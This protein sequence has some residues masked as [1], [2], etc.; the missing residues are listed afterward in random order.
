MKKFL[1]ALFALAICCVS[2]FAGGIPELTSPVMDTAGIM[3]ESRRKELE[4]YLLQIDQNS[5][6]QIVVYTVPTLGGESLEEYAI[7]AAR[8]WQLGESEDNKGV[9]LL[10]A[11]KE[12]KIRIETGYGAEGDLTDAKCGMIIRNI[13]AP[14]FQKENYSGGIILGAKAIAGVVARD[15]EGNKI[16]FE[17]DDDDDWVAA[18]IMG[19]FW[20][21]WFVMF[22]GGLATKFRAL[23]WLPWA[24]WFIRHQGKKRSSGFDDIFFG[25]SGFGGGSSGGFGGGGGF[26]GGGG[27]FGGGGASG[28]W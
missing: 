19:I 5:T 7:K 12:R 13:I 26:S 27:G 22:S 16:A 14:E 17:D 10:V 1:S 6:A 3:S 8:Y 21:V 20:I 15:A 28:G 9:L 23:S 2:T 4:E 24:S 18:L 25:G 11:Y